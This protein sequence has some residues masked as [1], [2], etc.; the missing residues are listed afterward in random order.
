MN[1]YEAKQL[2]K[3][4]G[5]EVPRGLLINEVEEVERLN[6]NFPVVVKTAKEG[7]LHKSDVGGVVLNVSEGDL[8]DVVRDML[9]RFG[10][11]VLVEEMLPGGVELIIGVTKDP[12]F[13]HAIMFGLGGIFTEVFRDVSFRVIPI[14]RK[15]AE[16]MLSEIK[17][18]KILEG[19][20][21][22]KVNRER[23]VELL[24]K[25]SRMVERE[26]WIEGMDLNPVLATEDRVVVL[27]A[28]IVGKR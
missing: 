13:G 24:L 16:A 26:S 28:K 5:I 7:I 22:V 1:E 15:D 11:P 6:L 10:S 9:S 2:L 4:Y 19:Y 12:S 27:D 23:I 18:R 17:G 20:R 14:N 3:E 25:V 8:K 21:G